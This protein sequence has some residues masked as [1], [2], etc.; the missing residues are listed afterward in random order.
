VRAILFDKTPEANWPVAWHQD[1][2][3]AVAERIEVQGFSAWSVKEGL[4]HVRPPAGILESM[5]T[6]RLHL[7][8]C[9]AANGALQVLPGSHRAGFLS[10]DAIRR[11]TREVSPR[12]CEVPHGGVLLMKPLVLHA[13][14]PST[15]PGHRRVLHI[16][17]GP[18]T[19]PGGLRWPSVETRATR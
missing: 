13:S 3:I 17:Y 5:I 15:Q 4:P 7:D 19:L 10:E 11:W 18:G 12:F 9:V 6:A 1:Q 2:I 14:S 8:D 16:E